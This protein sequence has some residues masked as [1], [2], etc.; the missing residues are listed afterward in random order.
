MPPMPVL[1]ILLSILGL[2]PFIVCGLAALGPDPVTATRMLTTLIDYA[3]LVLA[4]SAGIHWG[5]ELQSP[6]QNKVVGRARLGIA[7]AALTVAWIAIVLP[8][9]TV[10]WLTLVILIAAYIGAVLVEQEAAKRGLMPP[11][12]LWL[13]WGFTII[14]AAMLVTV[15]TLHLLGQTVVF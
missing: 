12:Y 8:I 10:A 2:V 9:V 11:H 7:A 6:Q 14:A 13:R 15:L 1:A 3:A 4:F 5:F